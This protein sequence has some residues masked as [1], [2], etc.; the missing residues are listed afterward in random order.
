VV[1][2]WLT[3]ANS[4]SIILGNYPE[5]LQEDLTDL[6]EELQLTGEDTLNWKDFLAATM[7]KSLALR[8]DKIRMAFDHFNKSGGNCL[9]VS[10]LVDLFG[11]ESQAR[12][13][14]GFIDSDGDNQITFEDFRKAIAESMEDDF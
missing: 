6:R 3:V 1:S 14:M 8:E 2:H 4:P 10:D 5:Q 12:E 7:D 9:Q 13:I 11:G